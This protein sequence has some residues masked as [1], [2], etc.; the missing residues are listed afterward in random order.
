MTKISRPQPDEYGEFYAGYVSR[1]PEG[2][3]LFTLLRQQ[4]D[5]LHTLLR[6][7]SDAD[8]S[9]RPAPEEWSIKEVIGH[10]C[11]T[12]RVFSYRTLRFARG[13][14]TPLTGFD[15]NEFVRGTDFN[16]RTMADLLDEFAAQ[17]QANILCFQSLTEEETNRRGVAS[18]TEFSVRAML[19]IVA[20]HVLHH[21]ESL[22][23]DYK[24]AI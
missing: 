7:I 18:N 17:R 16:L 23:T 9:I 11:D 15:Q 24:V 13:D 22:K 12:E 21:I 5:D 8:A 10:V 4:P 2:A 14:T 20:G 3:D 19:H 6:N 1:V